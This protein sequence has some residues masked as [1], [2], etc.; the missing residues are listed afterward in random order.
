MKGDKD[1]S[2]SQTSQDFMKIMFWIA[3]AI[4]FMWNQK[5]IL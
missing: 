2:F 5:L 3:E 1:S 4:N